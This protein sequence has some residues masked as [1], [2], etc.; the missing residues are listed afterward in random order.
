MS[1][2]ELLKEFSGKTATKN[3]LHDATKIILENKMNE[4]RYN[5]R[6]NCI[7]RVHTE[8]LE[9]EI[10]NLG[11]STPPDL[12]NDNFLAVLAGVSHGRQGVFTYEIP[13]IIN[14][15]GGD[16]SDLR[17][18]DRYN[19]G[20]GSPSDDEIMWATLGGA[21]ACQIQIGQGTTNADKADF[22]IETAF[23]NGG[24]EDN[25]NTINNPAYDTINSELPMGVGLTTTGTG[26]ISET[27]LFE[28]YMRVGRTNSVHMLARDNI[29]PVV[30][31]TGGQT[32]FV[33]YVLAL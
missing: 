16:I 25:R 4:L 26:D 32:V 9:H 17:V 18:F 20:N 24:S 31:F 6:P 2:Q 5:P 30:P 33:E 28:N 14:T 3:I 13:S 8:S 15:G 22:N 12:L 10:I 1:Y 19:I 23:A 21:G 27:G 11:G 7:S 29:S